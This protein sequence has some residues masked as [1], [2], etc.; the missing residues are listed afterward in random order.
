[1]A[2]PCESVRPQR[3]AT[4][5]GVYFTCYYGGMGLLMPVAGY[6]RDLTG[7][8]AAPL[9]FAGFLLAMAIAMLLLFRAVQSR[10]STDTHALGANRSLSHGRIRY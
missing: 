8:P 10:V 7:R 6:A 3:R 2:L 5:M 4:A 1:M 9:W